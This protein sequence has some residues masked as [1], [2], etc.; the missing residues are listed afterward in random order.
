MGKSERSNKK[1]ETIDMAEYYYNTSIKVEVMLEAYA[2]IM[3]GNHGPF[4][5]KAYFHG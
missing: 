2:D 4:R 5:Q 3:G 1:K